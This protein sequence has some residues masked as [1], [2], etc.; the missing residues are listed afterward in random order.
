MEIS[1]K[2]WRIT[3]KE[4][5]STTDLLGEKYILAEYP[6][7]NG[8]DSSHIHVI[9]LSGI[10]YRM[11]T[12]G[13]RDPSDVLDI[14]LKEM[15]VPP[16]FE[17]DGVYSKVL[18]SYYSA[19]TETARAIVENGPQTS[20]DSGPQVTEDDIIDQVRM[21]LRGGQETSLRSM[22]VNAVSQISSSLGSVRQ[23]SVETIRASQREVSIQENSSIAGLR[24]SISGMYDY[25]DAMTDEYAH[26]AMETGAYYYARMFPK[27][28][29]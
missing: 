19:S 3:E 21:V 4:V 27:R 23:E 29:S 10:A 22:S 11:E 25:L 12:L 28:G 14:T 18:E 16:G 15:N 7:N 17:I 2:S 9:P 5:R 20:M 13:I 24:S 1:V 8:S 26:R 6:L